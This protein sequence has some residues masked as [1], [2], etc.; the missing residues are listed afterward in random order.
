[1]KEIIVMLHSSCVRIVMQKNPFSTL[2]EKNSLWNLDAVENNVL[3]WGIDAEEFI[4]ES[5][6]RGI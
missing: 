6:I 2:I 4:V 1:M 3:V 5:S